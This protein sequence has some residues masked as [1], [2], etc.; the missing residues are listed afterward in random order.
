[1][2][3]HRASAGQYATNVSEDK[4]MSIIT[5]PNLLIGEKRDC[6]VEVTV[7]AAGVADMTTLLR[8]SLTY[9]PSTGQSARTSE[10]KTVT[11]AP[12]TVARPTELSAPL[13]RNNIVDSQINRLNGIEVIERATAL[14]DANQLDEARAVVAQAQSIMSSSV[15]ASHPST[16]AMVLELTECMGRLQTKREWESIGRSEQ[17][18]SYNVHKCQRGVFGKASRYTPNAESSAAAYSNAKSKAC[19]SKA[20][21]F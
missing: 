3:I 19:Q 4:R 20:S 13:P 8:A 2:L 15:S 7:P 18:E 6:C 12:C 5:Y 16:Q 9:T 14:A 1:M 11:C 17:M 10:D 21:F